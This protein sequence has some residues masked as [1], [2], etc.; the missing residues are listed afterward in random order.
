MRYLGACAT[1]G[2]VLALTMPHVAPAQ[3][4]VATGGVQP[5]IEGRLARPVRYRPDGDAFVIENGTERYNRPL[6]G[7]STA[8]RVD[9]GDRPEFILYLPGRGGR[10]GEVERAVD[11]CVVPQRPS[12]V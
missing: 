4:L 7:G 9:G 5:N 12:F 11:R 1:A 3:T 2:A 10:I 8:F 6:Y